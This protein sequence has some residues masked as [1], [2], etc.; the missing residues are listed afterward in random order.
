MTDR[1]TLTIM[2]VCFALLAY[3]AFDTGRTMEQRKHLDQQLAAVNDTVRLTE[4]RYRKDTLEFV[5][6]RT[7]WDTIVRRDTITITRGETTAV[8]VPLAQ[9]DSTIKACSAVVVSCEAARAALQRK[10]AVLEANQ[11]APTPAWKQVAVPAGW[12]AVGIVIGYIVRAT[13]GR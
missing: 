4:V 6:W 7:R 13:E 11:P 5:K 8:Y 9:A 1:S 12:T 2:A 10:V 3:A